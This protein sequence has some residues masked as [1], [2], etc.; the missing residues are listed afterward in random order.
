MQYKIGDKVVIK[1][2]D[3]YAPL[4]KNYFLKNGRIVTIRDIRNDSYYILN[5][6][7]DWHWTDIFIEGLA[8]KPEPK[9]LLDLTTTRFD[10]MD[11]E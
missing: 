4:V 11:F 5:E 9:K 10:L 6:L 1:E 3:N 8:P 2:N 7:E